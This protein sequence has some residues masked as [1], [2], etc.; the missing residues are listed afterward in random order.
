M[1]TATKKQTIS[2]QEPVAVKKAVAKTTAKTAVEEKATAAKK[3][4]TKATTSAKKTA[5]EKPAPAAVKT[6]AAKKSPAKKK[7][8]SVTV[9]HRNH[10]IATAAYYLAERRGF[11][12]GHDVQDWVAAELQIDAQLGE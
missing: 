8:S 1:V 6:A 4:A 3:P 11:A 9:E 5:T 10:M 7:S 2:A 12:V